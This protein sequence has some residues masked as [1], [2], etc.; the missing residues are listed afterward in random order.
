MSK[1]ELLILGTAGAVPTR[2][3]NHNGYLLRWDGQGIMFDPGEGTQRQMS[4]AGASATE[5]NWLCVTHFHG[6]HSLGV[7]GLIQRLGRDQVPH[8]VNAVFPQEGQHYWDRLKH[9]TSYF[10]E[11]TLV[12]HP[13]SGPEATV[14][15]GAFTITARPLDHSIPTY[16]Y[17]LA[18]P[19]GRTFLPDKLR[20]HGIS[21]PAIRDLSGDL[22]DECSVARP[23]QKVAFIMDTR[24]C[25][26]VFALAD[27]V[28]ML[29]I[30]STFLDAEAEQAAERAHLTARQAGEVARQAGVGTL[31][32]TH[33]SERYTGQ[34]DPLFLEQ[35]DFP[36]TVFA[37]DLDRVPLPPRRTAD[38]TG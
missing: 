30:E 33:F 15:G 36:N 3:R 10:G 37:H 23:G 22:L 4:H 18:E 2:R 1:R 12:E 26:N 17:R 9:A 20:E 31:V 34:H 14:D 16:G 29:I 19:D 13:V 32:L 6:D 21:G 8:D 38:V 7:P 27:G 35:A 24:I 25:D 5:L 11:P 28:D